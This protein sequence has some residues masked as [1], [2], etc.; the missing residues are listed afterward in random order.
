MRIVV[1][2]FAGDDDIGARAVYVPAHLERDARFGE[3]VFYMVL[4][5]P[6]G[7]CLPCLSNLFG[8]IGII[9]NRGIEA[10]LQLWQEN[11]AFDIRNSLYSS[12]TNR[13]NFPSAFNESKREMQSR[14]ASRVAFEIIFS[15]EF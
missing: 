13:T 5:R 12:L 6:P 11:S 14:I 7:P 3:E 15:C 8:L 2:G 1:S 9:V 10:T 4:Q